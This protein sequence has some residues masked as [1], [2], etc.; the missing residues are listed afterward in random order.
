MSDDEPMAKFVM[1]HNLE[2][3]KCAGGS[4]NGVH[5]EISKGKTEYFRCGR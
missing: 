3:N 1:V 5:F 2:W 4:F